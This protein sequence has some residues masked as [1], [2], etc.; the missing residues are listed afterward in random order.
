MFAVLLPIK[1]PSFLGIVLRYHNVQLYLCR[2]LSLRPRLVFH[3]E[4]SHSERSFFRSLTAGSGYRVQQLFEAMHCQSEGCGEISTSGMSWGW[5]GKRRPVCRA[6]YVTTNS[7][8]LNLLEPSGP[9]KEIAV[10]L[11]FY[12]TQLVPHRECLLP[13]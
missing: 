11:L 5:G 4:H 3:K 7:G 1:F 9:V 2:Q 12:H 13:L 10:P 6:D 8:S